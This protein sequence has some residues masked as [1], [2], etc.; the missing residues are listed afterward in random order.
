VNDVQAIAYA[1]MRHQGHTD[2]DIETAEQQTHQNSECEFTGQGWDCVNED[3]KS[4][5][6]L[7]DALDEACEMA[8][9]ALEALPKPTGHIITRIHYSEHSNERLF[10]PWGHVV[11]DEDRAA[12]SLGI[13]RSAFPEH[14]W[15]MYALT[16]VAAD[17]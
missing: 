13:A 16:E 15:R 7:S 1:W 5:H 3:G 14:P 12:T 8:N 4:R 9:V 6:P 2:A 11:L 17:Q 10:D